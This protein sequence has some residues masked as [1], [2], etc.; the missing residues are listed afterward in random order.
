MGFVVLV[1]SPYRF[2]IPLIGLPS[3]FLALGLFTVAGFWLYRGLRLPL[4]EVL[5]FMRLR[6]GEVMKNEVLEFL[7]GE[8]GKGRQLFEVLEKREWV[9]SAEKNLEMVQTREEVDE[10]LLVLLPEGNRRAEK[11]SKRKTRCS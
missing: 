9:I 3:V 7:D 5:V 1:D 11:L 8:E 10:N 2:P 4:D 6:G